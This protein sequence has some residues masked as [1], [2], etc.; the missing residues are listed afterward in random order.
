MANELATTNSNAIQ[1]TNDFRIPNG[2]IC[3]FNIEDVQ[4]KMKLAN[5]LNGAESMRDKVDQVLNVTDI[6]TTQ[7]NRARTGEVCTNSYLILEDGTVYFSQSDGIA[8]SL[9]V[10]VALFTNPATGEF[11]NPVSQG[12]GLQIKEQTLSNG[13]TLKTVVPVPLA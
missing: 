7:G 11:I 1:N 4:G 2:Y 3:T 6:V 9:K 10:I 12:V 13:N 8:R 5:A